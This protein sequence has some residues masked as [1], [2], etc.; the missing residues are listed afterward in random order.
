MEKI[1][2]YIV[3]AISSQKGMHSMSKKT[4]KA[5]QNV[6]SEYFSKVRVMQLGSL[7][8]LESLARKKPDLVFNGMKRLSVGN[9][10]YVS[11]SGFLE[12]GGIPVTGSGAD[13][14]ELERDKTKAKDMIASAG[15]GTSQ[16]IIANTDIDY[17]TSS[18]PL[19]FPL[20]I[21]PSNRGAGLGINADSVVRNYIDLNRGISNLVKN[22][23]PDI[24]I[25]NYLSGRE[26]SVVI[27][28]KSDDVGYRVM[29]LE[30][31]AP[32][33][34][35]GDRFLSGGIKHDDTESAV[36]VKPGS[37]R[38]RLSLFALESFEALGARDYGRIDIRLDEDGEPQFLEANLMPGLTDH[39]YFYRSLHMNNQSTYEDVIV[40]IAQLALAR[41]V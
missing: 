32:I 8:D 24:I 17:D 38:D 15:L 10:E 23:F 3:I 33:N 19:K 9:D 40:S 41:S 16:Y 11:V 14:I 18:L 26:F 36:V 30:L 35:N 34:K 4:A 20:F 29:P 21:K 5:I 28:R 6:L 1:D 27:L 12:D 31:V 7:A 39:G 22:N 25:E 13:A 2:K 37:L